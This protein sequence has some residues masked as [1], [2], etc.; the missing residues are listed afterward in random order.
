MLFQV[1][2]VNIILNWSYI[3]NANDR[4]LKSKKEDEIVTYQLRMQFYWENRRQ[5]LSALALR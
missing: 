4:R 1:L 5:K 2:Y 3:W